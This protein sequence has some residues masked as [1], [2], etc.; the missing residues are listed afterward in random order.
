MKLHGIGTD[1]VKINRLSNII[2]KNKSFLLR[3]FSKKEI[4]F[5]S[6]KKTKYNCLAKRFAAKESFSK[7]LGTGIAHGLSF[8]EIEIL[9]NKIGKPYINL[10]GKS[11][12]TVNKFLKKNTKVFLSLSDESNYAIAFVVIS[13]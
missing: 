2:K 9:N 8:N 6:K 13:K 1:I 12:K 3:V 5:C 10:K 4:S 11:L 7:A